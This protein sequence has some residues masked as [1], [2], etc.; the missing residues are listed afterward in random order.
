MKG[1]G[2]VDFPSPSVCLSFRLYSLAVLS[3]V[4][5]SHPFE[6][7]VFW[8]MFMAPEGDDL[9]ISWVPEGILWARLVSSNLAAFLFLCV[10]FGSPLFWSARGN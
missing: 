10:F 1:G 9:F 8:S 3:S 7:L 2:R 5:Q 4:A 6:L